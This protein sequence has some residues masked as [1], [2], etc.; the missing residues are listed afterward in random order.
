MPSSS[1]Y[2]S[3]LDDDGMPSKGKN[4]ENNMS[5]NNIGVH[6][7]N[8]D[9]NTIKVAASNSIVVPDNDIYYF[10]PGAPNPEV[11]IINA[12]T[13][14]EHHQSLIENESASETNLDFVNL[15]NV[16]QRLTYY[17][18]N[19]QPTSNISDEEENMAKQIIQ[20]WI[21]SDYVE[22]RKKNELKSLVSIPHP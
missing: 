20:D 12:E 8:S 4:S 5:I 9:L 2:E 17:V 10:N 13:S 18:S 6:D 3:A 16:I 21:K 19:V 15:A 22:D 11:Q 14:K 7:N 1:Y